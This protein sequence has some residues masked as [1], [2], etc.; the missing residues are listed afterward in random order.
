MKIIKYFIISILSI[1]VVLLIIVELFAPK[2]IMIAGENISFEKPWKKPTEVENKIFKSLI[3]SFN[4]ADC[5]NLYVKDVENGNYIL[6]CLKKD[7]KWDFYWAT[8]KNNDL[9]GLSDEIKAE[10]RPPE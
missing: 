9:M 8:P 4:F 5:E 1:L 6:A 3:T 2:T 7:K 10:I